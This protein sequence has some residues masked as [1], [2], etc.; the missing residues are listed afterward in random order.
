MA[1]DH[2]W[3]FL[4]S[5][6]NCIDFNSYND[7]SSGYVDYDGEGFYSN[8]DGSYG[9]RNSDGTGYYFGADGSYGEIYSDKTGDYFGADGSYGYIDLDGGSFYNEATSSTSSYLSS[10]TYDSYSTGIPIHINAFFKKLLVFILILGISAISIAIYV[11]LS[12]K[13]IPT[14]ISSSEC[15]GMSMDAVHERFEDAGFEYVVSEGLNDLFLKDIS[16]E[17]TVGKVSIGESTEFSNTDGFSRYD[18]VTIYYHT[19]KKVKVPITSKE[20]KNKN[21]QDVE[22]MFKNS[23]FGNITLTPKEDLKFGIFTKDGAVESVTIDGNSKYSE[24]ATY[25]LDA[26]IEI[27]YHTF[28]KKS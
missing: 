4:S 12:S 21:Y 17:N 13:P 8:T 27:D 14:G 26:D 25:R 20:A 18:K 5:T 1:K 9:V 19:L 2:G 28:P 3:E 23:R 15:K 11:S 24:D 16:K 6:D 7:G 10:S 22:N